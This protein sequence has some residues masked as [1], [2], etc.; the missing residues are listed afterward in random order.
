[1]SHWMTLMITT[2]KGNSSKLTPVKDRITVKKR[3]D[4]PMMSD[5]VPI[6]EMRS[7]HKLTNLSSNYSEHEEQL[8]NIYSFSDF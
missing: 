3:V 4:K 5:N 8:I 7:F 2:M 1:M 6:R